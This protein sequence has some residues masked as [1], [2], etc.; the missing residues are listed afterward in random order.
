VTWFLLL[1]VALMA[2][3]PLHLWWDWHPDRRPE[4]LR[5]AYPFLDGLRWPSALPLTMG[6]WFACLIFLA[7]WL[8]DRFGLTTLADGLILVSVIGAVVS[9]ALALTTEWFGW[10]S[11]LV[12]P[13]RRRS[14]RTRH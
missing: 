9:F 4:W 8:A 3:S 11:R 2:T 14:S 12:P 5:G 6:G 10:P 13:D 1:F 7:I